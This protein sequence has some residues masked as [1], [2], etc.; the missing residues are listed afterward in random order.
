MSGFVLLPGERHALFMAVGLRPLDEMTGLQPQGRLKFL[1]DRQV[2][3]GSWRQLP[4]KALL[5]PGGVAGWPGLERRADAL[6]AAPVRYRARIESPIYRPAYLASQDGIEFDAFP[7]N[8]TVPPASFANSIQDVEMLPGPLYPFPSHIPVLRGVVL[9]A[10]GAPVGN[11]VVR[12][13]ARERSLSD[14]RGEWALPLRWLTPG[15]L[16]P[17]DAEDQRT[18][19]TGTI[20]IQLPDA[21]GISHTI[22]I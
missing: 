1:L 7:Y 5:T 18:G 4:L 16:S 3:P 8:E 20:F 10:T 11:V 2:G 15:I 9:D 13:G 22:T 19:R 17:I 6:G 14:E 12:E 21:L